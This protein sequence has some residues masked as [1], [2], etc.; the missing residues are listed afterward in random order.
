MVKEFPQ[1]F[2]ADEF[3]EPDETGLSADAL[4][5]LD[6]VRSAY[7]ALKAQEQVVEESTSQSHRSNRRCGEGR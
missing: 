1:I 4:A 2:N 5:C 6:R 3:V 7:R